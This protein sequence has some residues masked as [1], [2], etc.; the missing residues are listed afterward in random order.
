MHDS[1]NLFFFFIRFDHTEIRYRKRR[2]ATDQTTLRVP[3]DDEVYVANLFHPTQILHPDARVIL[4]DGDNQ[5]KVDVVHPDCYLVGE[6]TS[7][8]GSASFS[9]CH[10]MPIDTSGKAVIEIGVYIDA[11]YNRYIENVGDD[12]LAKKMDFILVKWN[13][14]QYEYSKKEQLGREVEIQLKKM[15][16]WKTNPKWLKVSNKLGSLL[17]SICQWNKDK[18]PFDTIYLHTG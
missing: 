12:T 9:Y 11:D 2:F 18:E 7:H 10:G 3:V 4:T 13:A 17:H 1:R 14:V 8:G 15:E 16:F 6:V 5:Q